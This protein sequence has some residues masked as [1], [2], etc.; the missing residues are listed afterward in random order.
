MDAS[1]DKPLAPAKATEYI[2]DKAGPHLELHWTHHAG[3]QMRERGLIMGDVLHILKNGFVFE[4]GKPATQPGCFKYKME[5]NTPNSGGRK[6]RVVLIPST[7]NALKVV[8]VMWK[9]EDD[10]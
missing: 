1:Y 4:E 9:D 6:V 5:C 3:K 8:T 7:S 2:R 10:G